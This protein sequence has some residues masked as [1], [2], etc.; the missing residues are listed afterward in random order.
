MKNDKPSFSFSDD[1]KVP[2]GYTK[3]YCHMVFNIKLDLTRKDRLVAGGHQTKVPKEFV[4]LS[5]V[6]CDSVRIMLTIVYLNG[7]DVLAADVQ[8]ANLNAPTKEK[9]YTIVGPEFGPENEGRP[10]L[11]VC[12]LYGLRSSGACWR[13]HLVEIIQKMGFTACLADSDVWLQPNVKPGGDT[14]HEY[15]LVYVDDIPDVSHDPRAIMDNLS[16]HK[17]FTIPVTKYNW[18]SMLGPESPQRLDRKDG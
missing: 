10:V 17:T 16:K 4:H 13:D 3:I 6:S 18:T 1:N 14:Y 12:D 8:N 2:H 11:I 5:V 15:V 9:C 7:L